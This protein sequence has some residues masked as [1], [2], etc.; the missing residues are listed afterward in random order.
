M[1][2]PHEWS[3]TPAAG[4]G[5]ADAA[6]EHAA[7]SASHNTRVSTVFTPAS[8]AWRLTFAKRRCG[9]G[10]NDPADQ[11]RTRMDKLISAF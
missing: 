3:T 5:G 9:D 7:A 2:T 8:K 10:K 11:R 1:F 6:R 4:H